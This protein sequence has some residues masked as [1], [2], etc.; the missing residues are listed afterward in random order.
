M[1]KSLI[2]NGTVFAYCGGLYTL[3]IYFESSLYS[4]F[5]LTQ[6]KLYVNS[7]YAALFREWWKEEKIL[8]NSLQIF[9]IF[10]WLNPLVWNRQLQSKASNLSA[11]AEGS[12][13][14]QGT[15]ISLCPVPV[16]DAPP[17]K[18]NWGR[19][20]LFWVTVLEKRVCH[21]RE[22]TTMGRGGQPGS[23]DTEGKTKQTE[24]E[25]KF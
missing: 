20:G 19:K 6:C 23:Q 11:S 2:W 14:P 13:P 10:S 5:Y 8:C 21:G 18:A 15:C 1:L 22:G 25:A 3:P 4:L 12:Q 16:I 24:N 17:P 7:C 9:P